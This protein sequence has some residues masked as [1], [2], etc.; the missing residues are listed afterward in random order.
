MTTS[1]TEAQ[2]ALAAAPEPK[3]ATKPNARPRKPRV[4]PAKAK[5]AKKTTPAKKV[6]K[7]AKAAQPTKTESGAR[8]GSKTEKVL[9]LLKRP[10]GATLKEILKAT[11]WQPHSVRRLGPNWP[12]GHP[13]GGFSASGRDSA[14]GAFLLVSPIPADR[15]GAAG[16]HTGPSL[17]ASESWLI[18]FRRA[19]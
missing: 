17:G 4:A 3:A 14:P 19:R 10:D 5:S 18:R 15:T 6:A 13:L 11:G 12:P 2:T 7:G 8:P 16:N 9:D 1:N